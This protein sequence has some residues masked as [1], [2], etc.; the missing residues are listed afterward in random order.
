M[1]GLTI[2]VPTLG[3]VSLVSTLHSIADQATEEDRVVVVEDSEFSQGSA[4][5]VRLFMRNEALRGNWSCFNVG[6]GAPLGAFGHGARN[7]LLDNWLDEGDHPYCCTIDDDDVYAPGALDAMREAINSG[8][9]LSDRPY[10]WFIFQMIGGPNSHFKGQV[11]PNPNFGF[12][13]G[14]IGTP[15]IVAPVCGA[16]WGTWEEIDDFGRRRGSGY[17]GDWDMAEALQRELGD[18]IWVDQTVAIVRP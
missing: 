9:I 14:N 6:R 15:T 4:A 3:R 5:L 18:P 11:V 10:H 17:F 16:R 13:R 2:I 1:T 12:R 8:M 7:W